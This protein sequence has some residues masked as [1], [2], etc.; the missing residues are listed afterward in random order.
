VSSPYLILDLETIPDPA[1]PLETGPDGLTKMGAAGTNQ[2]LVAGCLLLDEYR[3][4]RIGIVGEGKGEAGI[5]L[6]LVRYLEEKKPTVVTWNGRGFDMPVI[7]AR[8][9]HHG[10]AMPWWFSDRN[11]RYRF[12]DKGHFDLMDYLSDFGAARA[13]K[14]DVFAKLCGFPGKVG[15][16]GSQVASMHAEG[17]LGEIQDY[18]LC[19]VVQTGA[20]FLR[21]QLLRGELSLA[22]YMEAA[23]AYLQWI[24]QDERLKPVTTKIDRARF[25]K[26]GTVKAPEARQE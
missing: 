10:L 25:L 19:D 24:D 2:I 22:A 1:F 11:T 16:D 13:T 4:K 5:V 17:K 7:T 14:L 18:C 23:T 26:S 3:P 9:F 8:A 15:V 21:T 20:V 12:T 6:D